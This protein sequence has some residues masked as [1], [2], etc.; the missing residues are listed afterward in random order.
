MT[1]YIGQFV[2]VRRAY[3]KGTGLVKMCFQN[4]INGDGVMIDTWTVI[5]TPVGGIHY[6]GRLVPDMWLGWVANSLT[7]RPRDMQILGTETPRHIQ[8]ILDR[9]MPPLNGVSSVMDHF[10]EDGRIVE[11]YEFAPEPTP[12]SDVMAIEMGLYKSDDTPLP[13]SLR[14]REP[15]PD[16][17]TAMGVFTAG[18]V[19]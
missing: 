7:D 18:L 16:V 11:P 4:I 15:D 8:E 5:P 6:L 12:S 14:E 19:R 3:P 10:I 2:S 17:Y 1:T 9:G 13:P